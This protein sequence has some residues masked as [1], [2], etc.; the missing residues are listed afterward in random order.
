MSIVTNQL[1]APKRVDK[2][3]RRTLETLTSIV[4][5]QSS[6]QEASTEFLR[7][8]DS[9]A[10]AASSESITAAIE[11]LAATDAALNDWL[12]FYGPLVDLAL[13]LVRNPS[14]RDDECDASER[15]WQT[16]N[17]AIRLR[18][19]EGHFENQLAQRKQE[20]IYHFAY[21][22]SHELN[23]PLANIATRA[24]VLLHSELAADRRQLLETIIDN[25]MRGSEMLGD[26]M[27]IARPP[28]MNIV[29]VE[30][31]CWFEQFVQRAK[32]WAANHR[33]DLK[34]RFSCDLS[35]FSFDPVAISEAVW[36]LVRNAIEASD[37]G[38]TVE[39]ELSQADGG[40]RFLVRDRGAG[41]SEEALRHCFDPYYSG[42]E[43]GRGLGLGLTKAKR[44]ADLHQSNLT[45][46]NQKPVGCLATLELLAPN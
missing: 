32:T 28:Q 39:L 42:R 3:A 43:A 19:I 26:L 5:R 45:I 33:V 6:M 31:S 36:C 44:I 16:S 17:L 29:V 20:A 22:L 7:Q 2:F 40:L 21:G 25:A 24:G 46:V 38:S 14:W 23:N 13:T 1:V 18:S 37:A 12:S 41:L 10:K 15:L 8:A 30:L 35:R 9:S 11:R 27:L 4:L 34:S